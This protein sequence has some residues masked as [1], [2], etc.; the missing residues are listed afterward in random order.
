VQSVAGTIVLSEFLQAITK[1]LGQGFS[2][3]FPLFNPLQ[4][5][6]TL[7]SLTGFFGLNV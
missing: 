7:K 3:G 4:R 5:M 2:S 1:Q 6:K